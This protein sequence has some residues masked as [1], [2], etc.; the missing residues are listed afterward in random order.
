MSGPNAMGR[1]SNS[2]WRSAR[3]GKEMHDKGHSGPRHEDQK[4]GGTQG[5]RGSLF[6]IPRVAGTL[7]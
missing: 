5:L 2:E 6:A 1:T 7:T 4:E 3:E